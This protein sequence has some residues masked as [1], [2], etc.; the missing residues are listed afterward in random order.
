MSSLYE[1]IIEVLEKHGACS[2]ER[3]AEELNS[4]IMN[5]PPKEVSI[6]S[7]KSAISRKKD[8]FNVKD[9]IISI[10]SNREIKKITI[11]CQIASNRSSTIQIDFEKERYMIQEWGVS[12]NQ[13]HPQIISLE[14]GDYQS[15][16]NQLYT[17]KIWDWNSASMEGISKYKVRL[18]TTS[19]V[20]EYVGNSLVEKEWK[21]IRKLT[22][23]FFDVDYIYS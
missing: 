2:I 9:S 16:K 15:L 17:L 13:K 12:S 3:I 4:N 22:S 23:Q 14:S 18:Q 19:A 11:E 8:L 1:K 21:Q 7:V 20:Y 5:Q 6:S 10:H